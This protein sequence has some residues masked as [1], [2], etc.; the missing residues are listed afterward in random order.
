MDGELAAG[1]AAYQAKQA[2]NGLTPAQA[3]DEAKELAG[4]FYA[5]QTP[6]DAG[7]FAGVDESL[8]PGNLTTIPTAESIAEITLLQPINADRSSRRGR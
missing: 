6:I 8:I 7:E 4:D 2:T 1:S 3:A 5:G